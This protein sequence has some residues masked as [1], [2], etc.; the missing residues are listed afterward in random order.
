MFLRVIVALW[1]FVV[2]VILS[3]IF[4]SKVVARQALGRTRDRD[5]L[6]IE[7]VDIGFSAAEACYRSKK[8][9][10]QKYALDTETIFLDEE[11]MDDRIKEIAKNETDRMLSFYQR[12]DLIEVAE[13]RE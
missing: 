6:C 1:L 4:K 2:T 8:P 9:V 13:I 10:M 5:T 12:D 7:C 11:M 3:E